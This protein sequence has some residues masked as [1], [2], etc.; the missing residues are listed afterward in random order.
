MADCLEGRTAGHV[1]QGK[2]MRERQGPQ[3][4]APGVT[5]SAAEKSQ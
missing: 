1:K 3:R 5:E 2:G 4:A